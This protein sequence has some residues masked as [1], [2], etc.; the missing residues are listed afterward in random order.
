MAKKK[1]KPQAA[2]FDVVDVKMDV[3][4]NASPAKVWRA[5]ISDSSKW[6]PREFYTGPD[7]EGFIFEAKLGGGVYETWTN[8][9]GL[10]WYDVIG[11]DPNRSLLMR[12]Q[13]TARYG[14][15]A[16]SFLELTLEADGKATILHLHDNV[17]G[18][19]G[20]K[21]QDSLVAGWKIL[22]EDSLKKFVEGNK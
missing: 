14:G 11:V 1:A 3:R 16:M 17:F 15:P 13:L 18:V 8:G 22:M 2:K 20:S 4:I 12:G 9:G 19:I 6:W 5:I 10:V 21:M 7:P